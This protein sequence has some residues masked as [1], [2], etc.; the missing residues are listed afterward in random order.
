MRRRQFLVVAGVATAGCLSDQSTDA[1]PAVS[2]DAEDHSDPTPDVSL[3]VV[4]NAGV[5]SE[6]PTD[7]PTIADDGW[8]WLLVRMD[9]TNLGDTPR[10]LSEYQYRVTTDDGEFGH[11]VTKTQWTLAGKRA[12][13]S[14]TASGWVVFHIPE[15]ASAATLSVRENTRLAY[16][17]AFNQDSTLT[18]DPNSNDRIHRRRYTPH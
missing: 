9:V 1:P 11:V 4:Y 17:V 8:K 7:P 3:E 6:L 5:T 12:A 14:E 2:L 13:P 16:D 15:S 18:T 10:E